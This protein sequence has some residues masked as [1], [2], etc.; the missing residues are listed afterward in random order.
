MRCRHEFVRD[1]KF[2]FPQSAPTAHRKE[3]KQ[4]FV[5]IVDADLS[6]LGRQ[7]NAIGRHAHSLRENALE[8]LGNARQFRR[9]DAFSIFPR[10]LAEPIEKHEIDADLQQHTIGF[11]ADMQIDVWSVLRVHAAKKA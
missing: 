2:E 3:R 6:D 4:R 11:D 8:P 5:W 7:R 1:F 9:I 10:K